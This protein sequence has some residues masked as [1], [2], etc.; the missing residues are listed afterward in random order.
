MYAKTK[1]VG[2]QFA[3]ELMEWSKTGKAPKSADA[4]VKYFLELQQQRLKDHDLEMEYELW[5]PKKKNEIVSGNTA[6][7]FGRNKRSSVKYESTMDFRN[8]DRR[9]RFYRN[10]K[11]RFSRTTH[12]IMYKTTTRLKQGEM[13]GTE[14][15][16]CPECGAISTIIELQAGCPYCNAKFVMSDLFPKVTDFFY[17]RNCGE[18]ASSLKVKILKWILA[19]ILIV[20]AIQLFYKGTDEI[21]ITVI[22]SIIGG[23]IFGYVAWAFGK[24]GSLF[25]GAAKSIMPMVRQ[26]EAKDKITTLLHGFDPSFSYQYFVNRLVSKL[27]TVLFAKDRANLAVYEG[28][29]LRPELDQIIESDFDSGI[30]LNTYQAQNGYC[31][32]SIDLYMEDIYDNGSRI[33]QKKDIFRLKLT[34]NV[35]KPEDIAFSM[36]KVECKSCGASFDA[37]KERHCPY[38]KA[39]Y[40]MKEDD[41]VISY[42]EQIR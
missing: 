35:T 33:Y 8:F 22:S 16:C 37:T 4:D 15:Y 13:I 34:K 7:I 18:D 26:K 21:I 6:S 29:Q 41:W 20:F 23:A 38:C 30:V 17:I 1:E 42:L 25:V 31:M 11:K 9:I 5:E 27:K 32:L 12:D 19:A 40:D 36:K 24:I 3:R 28:T 39:P 14:T 2:D 10:G